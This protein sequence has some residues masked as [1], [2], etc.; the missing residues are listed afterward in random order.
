MNIFRFVQRV[1]GF[2]AAL[3]LSILALSPATVL[4][5]GM[6]LVISQD[7][8]L[9]SGQVLYTGGQPGIGDFISVANLTDPQLA[10]LEAT[11]NAEGR[12]TVTGVMGHQYVAT[13][14]GEEGHTVEVPFTLGEEI[15]AADEGG[16]PFYVIAGVLLLLSIVPA[17]YMRKR[18][19][20]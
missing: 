4:A 2:A 20:A 18:Q 15:V 19:N 12:F 10:A 6:D 3:A 17:T 16:V 1:R 9:I 11:T 5:H 14:Y 13:A 8:E 7:G